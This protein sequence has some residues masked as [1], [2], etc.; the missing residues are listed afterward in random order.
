MRKA[1]FIDRDNT[2]NHDAGYV[3]RISDL[4]I[5]PEIPTL[6]RKYKRMGYLVIVLTNQS[7]IGRGHFTEADMKA[8][9]TKSIAGWKRPVLA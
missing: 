6:I 1:L 3:Y 7:G 4:K 9:N 5:F 8:F 2:I